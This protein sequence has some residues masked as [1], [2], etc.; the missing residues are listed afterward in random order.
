[1]KENMDNHDIAMLVQQV[2]KGDEKAFELLYQQ[3]NRQIYYTC[4]SFL[5]NEQDIY[6][7][8]QDTYLQAL[9]RIGQLREPERFVAWLNQIAINVRICWERRSW[10]P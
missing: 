9:T 2:L 10:S 7:V 3:T 8:M 4:R 5:E 1:M 6:D